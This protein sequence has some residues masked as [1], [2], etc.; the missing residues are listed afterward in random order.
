MNNITKFNKA[1]GALL[2]GIIGLLVAYGLI[3]EDLAN[4]EFVQEGITVLAAVLGTYLAPKN[5][6]ANSG[7][8]GAS[9]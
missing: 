6:D 2:G 3:P 5:K 9:S 7:T 8:P 4:Q 1:I